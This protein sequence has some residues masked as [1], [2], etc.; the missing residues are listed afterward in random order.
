MVRESSFEQVAPSVWRLRDTCN[1]YVLAAD[2]GAVLVDLGSGAVLEH[3]PELGL[4]RVTDVLVTHFHRDQ[5]QG[6]ARAVAA[7]ARVWVPPLE[8]ELIAGVDRRWQARQLEHDYDLRQDRFAL[9]E[10]VEVAGVVAEY[11]SRS[12][13]GVNA[14]ALP[15]PGHTVG[16]ITYLVEREGR[17][18]AFSGDLVHGDGKVWSLAATQWS[19][20]GIE[21]LAATFFSCGVLERLGP[22]LL[23]P[24]HGDVVED[25]AATLG[26]ARDRLD[27]LAALRLEEPWPLRDM[28]QHPWAELTPHLLRNRP[29]F[30][31]S[32]ALLSESGC[33]L[34]V[35]FGYDV[36]TGMTPQTDRAAKRTLLWPLDALRSERGVERIEAVV[37]THYHD[38]HVAGLN[39]LRELE[40]TEVWAPA[41]VAPVLEDPE[42]YD[43]P[44]LWHE[45][46]RVDR[47]LMLGRP[48]VWHEYDL[49]AHALPGHTLYAAALAFEADGRRV[50]AIGDQHTTAGEKPILNYQYRNRYRVGDFVRTAELYR[51]LRPDLLISGHW[52]PQEVT[53]EWLARLE[54]DAA[55]LEELHRELLPDAV[56]FGAEG[57]GARIEPYRSSVASG[58]PVALDVTVRNP[59]DRPERAVVRL[60]VPPGWPEPAVHEVELDALGE[61]TLRFR[62]ETAGIAPVRRARLAAD[63]TVGESPFGQQAEALLDVS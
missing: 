55:R 18:L 27:E 60:V 25:P 23:L 42:R 31:N 6:L 43:L 5:V 58:D 51:S 10:P 9:L 53:E 24:A 33:A 52:Q 36:A 28:L 57:F 40:G 15:T 49:T 62:V 19:Y 29:S 59:F 26:R 30:A 56:D 4:A 13:G 47:V 11:R 63:L 41:N 7:G 8:H 44:C 45:P 16:S 34:L 39:M 14:Y 2:D 37:V 20:S 12:Y 46:I 22:D 1:V 35:D 21:G 17:R 32:Y 38:D 50:L 48:V 54:A 61:E 3:L